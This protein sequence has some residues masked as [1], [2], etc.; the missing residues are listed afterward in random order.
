MI[1]TGLVIYLGGTWAAINFLPWLYGVRTY[2]RL[3]WLWLA[4][5][6]FFLVCAVQFL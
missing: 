2:I 3:W 5:N 4:A 1:E 6:V